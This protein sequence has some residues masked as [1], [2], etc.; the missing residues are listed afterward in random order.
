MKKI[1]KYLY[2]YFIFLVKFRFSLNFL[3][4]EDK[5]ISNNLKLTPEDEFILKK[6]TNSY[7]HTKKENINNINYIPTGAWKNHVKKFKSEYTNALKNKEIKELDALFKNF[8]RNNGIRGIWMYNSFN[9][10]KNATRKEKVEFMI[11]I[12]RDFKQLKKLIKIKNINNLNFPTIGNPWGLKIN[13]TTLLPTS[14]SHYYYSEQI[15]EIIK[16]IE[17]PIVCEIGGGF[18]GTAYYM[19]KE[20]KEIR[21]LNFDI[22]EVLIFCKYFLMKN[23]PN[24]KILTYSQSLPYINK[25]TLKDYEII[26]MP[27]FMLPK[28]EQNLFDLTFNTRS[29]SEMSSETVKE[30]LKQIQ[31]ITKKFFF[32]DNSDVAYLQR[33]SHT[34]V[35]SSN[36]NIDQNI[37]DLVYKKKNFLGGGTSYRFV[38]HLFKKI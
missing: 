10:I 17:R 11:N 20:K 36:F 1:L 24:K 25:Q 28:I 9:Q 21:Y 8:F 6:I 33:D 32:H 7:L 38:E 29:L 26:L 4:L 15:K 3:D 37:F 16:D 13:N 27:N 31:R 5:N 30:Y 18:G 2:R 23:F 35:K 34:E 14:S 12:Y 22:P 19:L